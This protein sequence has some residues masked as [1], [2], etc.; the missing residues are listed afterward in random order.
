MAAVQWRTYIKFA[1]GAV[2]AVVL[3]LVGLRAAL[4]SNAVMSRI[5]P[6]VQSVLKTDFNIDSKIGE[7]SIDLLGRVSLKQLEARWQDPQLGYAELAVD[8]VS[9]RFSLFQLIRRR[10]QVASVELR[11]P[12]VSLKLNI[13]PSMP[14]ESTPQNPLPLIRSLIENPPVA[15]QVDRIAV[16]RAQLD[17]QLLETQNELNFKAQDLNLNASLQSEKGMINAEFNMSVDSDTQVMA[18]QSNLS[19]ALRGFLGGL[20]KTELQSKLK[21]QAN[22][23]VELNFVDPAMPQFV[24]HTMGLDS[25]FEFLSLNADLGKKGAVSV[26]SKELQAGLSLP[27]KV[28]LS[29]QKIF[30]LEKNSALEFNTLIGDGIYQTLG[31]IEL[32]IKQNL[33]WKYLRFGAQIVNP[34]LGMELE[35]QA[36]VSA[37]VTISDKEIAISSQESPLSFTLTKI[38]AKTPALDKVKDILQLNRIHFLQF[39]TPFSLNFS[40]PSFAILDA[41]LQGMRATELAFSPILFVNEKANPVLKSEVKVHHEDT[42]V[43]TISADSQ[44]NLQEELHAPLPILSLGLPKE[45]QLMI[46]HNLDLKVESSLKDLEQLFA[47]SGAELSTWLAVDK[48]RVADIQLNAANRKKLLLSSGKVQLSIPLKLREVSP[49]LKDLSRL[50]GFSVN[51][52]WDFKLPHSHSSALD[53][54]FSKAKMLKPV[55]KLKSQVQFTEKPTVPLFDQQ[56]LHMKSP[57]DLTSL[58]SL[59]SGLLKLNAE[60]A[61]PEIGTSSLAVLKGI[62]GKAKVVT[63]F[64]F[65]SLIQLKVDAAV[66]ELNPDKSLQL[67]QETLPYLKNIKTTVSAKVNLKGAADVEAVDL[68]TGGDLL[69]LKAQGGSDLNVENSRF[70]GNIDVKLPPKYRY[71][72]RATD[73]VAFKGR[74]RADWEATQKALKTLRLRGTLSLD[75]FSVRHSLAEVEK[76]KGSVPFEQMLETQELKSL[77]WSYLIED[78]PFKRVD[79]SKFTPLTVQDSLVTIDRV[80]AL[81]RKFGP[82][83]A[84]VSLKQ[85]MLNVDKLDADI[86]EG[87]LAGQA[88][89]DIQPSKFSTGIQG[90]ITKLNTS[91]LS[92]SDRK[93]PPAPLSAR[94]S[95]MVDLSRSLIEGRTD[96]TE[97]GKNQLLAFIDVLDPEGTDALLNKARLGLGVGYPRYV[98][99][100]M[101]NGY[102]DMNVALGGV[103]EQSIEIKNLPLSPIVNAKTQDIVKVMREVPIQ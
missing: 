74:V 4:R 62:E 51:A 5:L 53:L 41:P 70:S 14:E 93:L 19:V 7:L 45:K 31:L 43:I 26:T 16:E 2:A 79:T 18:N 78:N 13:Q 48:T 97:I 34:D 100:L 3:L 28:S 29:L 90:R 30:E 71:G 84:R 98:G 9:L 67:P 88:Y 59:D 20:R 57:V 24:I 60:Y 55:L 58:V 10:L 91:L 86:F 101:Q 63:E 38:A 95:L 56:V 68:S 76:I 81:G 83:R 50:G 66:R 11:S 12:K 87:V 25:N 94:L 92:S 1:L 23:A 15:F 40:K 65:K 8:A 32:K 6:P 39:R 49:L 44:L 103:I 96:V 72:I 102:L 69:Y 17:V 64:P 37:L 22:V 35:S 85:N 27:A 89:V 54:D 77:K 80:A 42:G 36:G 21:L 46:D 52:L 99:L 75:E 82:I 33:N 73:Q 61:L 47:L